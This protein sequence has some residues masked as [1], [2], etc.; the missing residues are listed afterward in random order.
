MTKYERIKNMSI[1]EMAIF[2]AEDI[3]HGDCY[4]CG[5][6]LKMKAPYKL[7]DS[8]RDAWLKYLEGDST[9]K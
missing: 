2:L 1:E 7:G 6:C 8:C 9:Q 3:P 4:G 5:K